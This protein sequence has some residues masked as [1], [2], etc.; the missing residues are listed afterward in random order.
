MST[1]VQLKEEGNTLFVAKMYKQA[2]AK[3]SQA[4]EKDADNAVLYANR[5]ACNLSLKRWA[6][7]WLSLIQT[8]LTYDACRYKDA[9]SDAKKVRN[10]GWYAFLRRS[11]VYCTQSTELDPNYPKG[12]GRLA[13]AQQARRLRLLY[14][15]K[16]AD[17]GVGHGGPGF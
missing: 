16:Y 13:T 6:I 4:I 10:P 8:R 12:W 1:A 15:P 11:R 17:S 2:L 14:A 3:Y 9:H 7:A 5:A